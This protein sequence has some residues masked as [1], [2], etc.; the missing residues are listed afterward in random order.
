[1][2][3]RAPQ[4]VEPIAARLRSQPARR[5]PR[6]TSCGG[7]S[8]LPKYLAAR[9]QPSGDQS[10]GDG[11]RS[12]HDRP[13]P[14]TTT[15]PDSPS[16][17]PSLTRAALPR[18]FSIHVPTKLDAL[19]SLPRWQATLLSLASQEEVDATPRTARGLGPPL[20]P[21]DAKKG[22]PTGPADLLPPAGEVNIRYSDRQ[23]S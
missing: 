14:A 2:D 22:K 5:D 9:H 16:A 21:P 1:M 13:C 6:P 18:V 4:L 12:A 7:L 11:S 8:S 17:P 15:V 3:G 20:A 10:C 23:L 19:A